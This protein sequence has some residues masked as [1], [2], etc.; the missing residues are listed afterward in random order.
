MKAVWRGHETYLPVSDLV[1]ETGNTYDLEI[2]N[3]FI[4]IAPGTK[5]ETNML[6]IS[7][8]HFERYWRIIN[9]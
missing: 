4:K 9:E 7:E 1:L 8:D 6:Y 3:G 2:A 5:D